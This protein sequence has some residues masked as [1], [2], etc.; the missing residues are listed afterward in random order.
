S[1]RQRNVGD[2]RI[3]GVRR[4]HGTS[5]SADELFVLPGVAEREAI[6]GG[7]FHSV[8]QDLGN[9]SVRG[10]G[11]KTCA[12]QSCNERKPGYACAA[13]AIPVVHGFSPDLRASSACVSLFGTTEDEPSQGQKRASVALRTVVPGSAWFA[14]GKSRPRRSAFWSTLKLRALLM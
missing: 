2:D 10:R 4:I 11:E 13:D 5:G 9:S 12:N 14:G 6:E 1:R 7:R 3:R 8:D